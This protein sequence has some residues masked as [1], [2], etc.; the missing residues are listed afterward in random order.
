MD[1]LIVYFVWWAASRV[2]AIF[3]IVWLHK[4][5]MEAGKSGK[6]LSLEELVWISLPFF[7]EAGV[8]V[9]L[10]VCAVLAVLYVILFTVLKLYEAALNYIAKRDSNT[11]K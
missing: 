11:N 8:I 6:E 1:W 9:T 3:G 4:K 5:Q 2:W 7:L 10:A